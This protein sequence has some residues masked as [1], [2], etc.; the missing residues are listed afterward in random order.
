LRGLVG[1]GRERAA[2]GRREGGGVARR[3][4]DPF[5]PPPLLQIY[6]LNAAGRRQD[7]TVV[8]VITD[9]NEA[10]E[11]RGNRGREGRRRARQ[12]RA[13]PPAPSSPAPA[14]SQLKSAPMVE[15]TYVNSKSEHKVVKNKPT[16]LHRKDRG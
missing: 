16:L 13:A 5:P 3:G 14:P 10:R 15:W 9:Q 2:G 12:P 6:F 11:G 4:V 8:R 1:G 7:G